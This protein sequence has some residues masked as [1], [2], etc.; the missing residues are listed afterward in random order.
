MHCRIMSEVQ[1]M[2][3]QEQKAKEA[4]DREPQQWR[5]VVE[6]IWRDH[7]PH[8]RGLVCSGDDTFVFDAGTGYYG[9]Q[10]KRDSEGEDD[11]MEGGEEEEE[12]EERGRDADDEFSVVQ[13]EEHPRSVLPSLTSTKDDEC[14][15]TH[16]YPTVSIAIHS[17]KTDAATWHEAETDFICKNP[18][19]R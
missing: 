13:E 14:K 12:E 4:A 5:E 6:D 1:H 9:F 2:I 15:L 10:Y 18:K 16:F 19:R 7:L 17:V 3:D 8:F 11:L